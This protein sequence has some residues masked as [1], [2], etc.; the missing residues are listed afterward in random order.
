[1][2]TDLS[3]QR[4]GILGM[5]RSGIGAARLIRRLGGTALISDQKTESQAADAIAI[6]APLGIEIELGGHDRI[7]S[8]ALDTI[9]VSPGVVIKSEWLAKWERSGTELWSEL[10]LASRCYD[11]KWVGVTGSNGKTTTVTLLTEMLKHA[12]F[13]AASVG[14][15]GTAWSEFLPAR[16]IDI[17]VVEVSSFQLEFTHTAR[18]HVCVILNVL[19]NHLDRHGDLQTYGSLKL[20][21][22]ANQNTGNF[23]VINGDDAFLRSHIA[24]LPAQVTLFGLGTACPWFVEGDQLFHLRDGQA[25]QILSGDEWLL[26]GTHNLLNAAAAASAADCFGATHKEIRNTLFAATPVEHRIEF[27]R[28][29]GGVR[30]VNDSKS[31]NLTATL[32]AVSAVR[33]DIILLF[34]GRAKKESFAPLRE[35]L[36]KKVRVMLAYGESRQKVRDEIGENA[37]VSYAED[38]PEALKIAKQLATTEHTVLLSPGCA[39]YDQFPNFEER[40]KLFKQLVMSL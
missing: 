4:F 27:V 10:E 39:S 29:V 16:D 24:D 36:G 20:K 26:E 23:A 40:G 3:G 32:T 17:F 12:G 9:I 28:E 13:R 37:F 18:P 11:G 1:M 2:L 6:L 5:G 25:E 19:E 34:G 30:Y 8:E 14:N 22:G 15:I 35:L 7:L 38:I 31:T 21:I 33:G